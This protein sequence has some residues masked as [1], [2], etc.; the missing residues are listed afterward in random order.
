MTTRTSHSTC[1]DCMAC[2]TPSQVGLTASQSVRYHTQPMLSVQ[3]RLLPQSKVRCSCNDEQRQHRLEN[4][5]KHA[6]LQDAMNKC[7]IYRL[8]G[9]PAYTPF[10][11]APDACNSICPTVTSLTQAGLDTRSKNM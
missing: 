7:V 10:C 1:L 5:S 4:G 11:S 3:S 8:P 2:F 6:V 9:M